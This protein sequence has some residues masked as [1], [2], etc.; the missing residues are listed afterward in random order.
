MSGATFTD[1]ESFGLLKELYLDDVKYQDHVQSSL[2]NFVKKA[3]SGEI[4]FDGNYFNV[5]VQFQLNE[6]YAAIQDNERLPEADFPK[7]VF[8]R[9]RVKQMYSV[10]EMTT[11]AATRGHKDGRPNGKYLDDTMKGTLLSFMS[12]VDSD[13]Y[14]NGRGYRATIAAGVTPAASSFPVVSSMRLRAGMKLDWY[15]A[16]LATKRGSIKIDVR[17]ID[18]MA[19]TAYLDSTF[20]GG[21]VPAGAVAGDVLVVYNALA[22]NEPSDGRHIAGLDRICDNT[23]SLG[24]LSPSQYALWMATNINVAG[25]NPSQEV[26]QIH[27]DSQYQIGGAYPDRMVFNPAWKRGYLAQFLNQR[28]FNS[29]TFDTGASKISF[30]PTKMGMDE[31]NKK[32]G[33][34]QMLEDKNCDPTTVYLWKYDAFCLGSDYS[35]APHLADEDGNEFRFRVGYD[36]LMGFYRWWANTVVYQRNLIGKQYGYA[37]Q[38]GTL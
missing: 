24:T 14:S 4:E 10:L 13:L 27:W 20:G 23:L 22:A 5:P 30:S 8:G 12:N 37:S 1:L 33:D 3:D 15:D 2:Q 21:V 35:D 7:G 6:S 16:T 32:P 9:Y 38:S 19:R 18:R 31:K 26:L 17:A 36:S 29:N 34:F 11:F 25:A 28:R